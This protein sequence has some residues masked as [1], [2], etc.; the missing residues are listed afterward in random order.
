M[1]AISLVVFIMF[2]FFYISHYQSDFFF[3]AQEYI[4][5]GR[6]TFYPVIAGI[7]MSVLLYGLHRLVLSIY[8]FRGNVFTLSYLP[9]FLLLILIEDI[10]S[11]VAQH[12]SCWHLFFTIPLAIVLTLLLFRIVLKYVN[13]DSYDYSLSILSKELWVNSLIMLGM[14]ILTLVCS[15]NNNN[16]RS[17]ISHDVYYI[18]Q[19]HDVERQAILKAEQDSL[20]KIFVADSIAAA[21][22]SLR[23]EKLRKDSLAELERKQIGG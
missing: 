13:R 7:V 10:C 18:K 9:S 23:K 22:D 5:N 1:K 16:V 17:S 15:A 21:K 3:V 11:S 19:K 8:K 12:S 2:V 6:T 20:R 4:A 14:M